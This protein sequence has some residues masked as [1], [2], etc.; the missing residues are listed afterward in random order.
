MGKIT[1][2][3]KDPQDNIITVEDIDTDTTIS[4]LR[5]IFVQNGGDS[6]EGQ[7]KINAKIIKDEDKISNFI[8]NG[9]TLKKITIGVVSAVRGGRKINH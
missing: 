3:F 1:I 5:A 4:A 6:S 8:P 2:I 7:W 9:K